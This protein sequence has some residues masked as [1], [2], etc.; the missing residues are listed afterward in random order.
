MMYNPTRE[1][2]RKYWVEDSIVVSDLV[3]QAPKN[4]RNPYEICLEKM[5]VDMVSD[6]NISR[7]Y[8]RSEISS[9]I[10]NAI[11]SYYLDEKKLMRYAGRRGCKEEFRELLKLEE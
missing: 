4:S 9:V 1:E 3:T 8:S 2:Y 6:K 11:K 10:D 7:T 5:L